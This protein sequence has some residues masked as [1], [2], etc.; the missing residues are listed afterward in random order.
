MRVLGVDPGTIATGWGVVEQQGA[1]LQHIGGGA[2]PNAI[3]PTRCKAP[4]LD[5]VR[6]SQSDTGLLAVGKVDA[7]RG[8]DLLRELI[9]NIE[10]ILDAPLVALGPDVRAVL[11]VDQ[12]S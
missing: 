2:S 9:L 1:R 8:D 3:G 7:Q 10:N 5:I 4:C 11:R 12:F 6:R